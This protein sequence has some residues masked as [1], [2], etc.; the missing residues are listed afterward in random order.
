MNYFWQVICANNAKYEVKYQK[1]IRIMRNLIILILLPLFL[2]SCLEKSTNY[3][4]FTGNINIDKMTLPD[5]V[6]VGDTIQ[7]QVKGGAPNGCWSDLELVMSQKNDSLIVVSGIGLYESTDGICTQVYQTID[8]SFSFRPTKPGVYQFYAY[9]ANL[10][11]ILD[12]L[13]VVSER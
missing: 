10:R 1:I 4:R 2:S 11:D 9:S 12:S 3:A 6:G 13:V 7:V 5:T 8:S